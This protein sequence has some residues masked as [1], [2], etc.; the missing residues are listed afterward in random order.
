MSMRLDGRARRGPGCGS[1]SVAFRL[2]ERRWAQPP[3]G[4]RRHTNAPAVGVPTTLSSNCCA[5]TCVTGGTIPT[6]PP[7]NG[8][9]STSTPRPGSPCLRSTWW[10]TRSAP[11][12]GSWRRRARPSDPGKKCRGWHDEVHSLCPH[13]TVAPIGAIRCR[14]SL[15]SARTVLENA[16]STAVK[17]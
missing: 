3:A 12:S 2:Q 9:G 14:S 5:V 7:Q 4:P 13:E 10:G 15:R 11:A 16:I 8:A 17:M 6:R 1:A